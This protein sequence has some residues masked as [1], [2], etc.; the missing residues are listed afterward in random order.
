LFRRGTRERDLEAEL[1]FHI[2]EA[3][4]Q[5]RL[6]GASSE[7]ALR[8]ALR[9][10]GNV[11]IV[12]EDTRAAWSWSWFEQLSQDCRYALRG[13]RRNPLF[14]AMAASSLALGIGANTAISSF[15]DAL[16]LRSLPVAEPHRLA[17]L[18]WHN[19]FDH[20]TVFHG[21]SG[22]VYDDPKYGSSARIFPYPA[23]EAFQKSQNVFS[24]LF[25]YLPTRNLNLI[26]RGQAEI[27]AAE[28]V[29]GNFFSGPRTRAGR[30][31]L[32]ESRR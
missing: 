8:S 10:L 32:A 14:T 3:A 6:E 11:G 7:H 15:L 17:V 29:S 28:Y 31:P 24:T 5:N 30:G 21:G 13:M 23:F 1:R 25:A 22:S 19:S 12:R 16:L 2:E 18:N 9:D 26:I 4:E 27:A 20:D